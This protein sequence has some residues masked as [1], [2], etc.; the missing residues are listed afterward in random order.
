MN[1]FDRER[2]RRAL[3]ALEQNVDAAQRELDQRSA[4]G[5][6]VSHLIVDAKTAMI[7]PRAATE[8][9]PLRP[10]AF[11]AWDNPCPRKGW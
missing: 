7:V 2:A 10:G 6:D 11:A 8:V 1:A 9:R 5:E 3:E 4:E